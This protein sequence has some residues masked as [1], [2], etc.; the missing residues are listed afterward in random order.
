[1]IA[2]SYFIVPAVM[3]ICGI[4]LMKFPPRKINRFNGYRTRLSMKSQE[5]WDFAQKYSGKI[6]LIMGLS[7]LAITVLAVLLIPGAGTNASY[8][9]AAMCVQSLLLIPIVPL[10]ERKLKKRG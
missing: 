7:E 10:V 4:W 6:Y 1:M 5:N 8:M 9:V 3:I 2:A